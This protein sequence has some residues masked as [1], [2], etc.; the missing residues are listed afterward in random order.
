MPIIKSLLDSTTSPHDDDA[1]DAFGRGEGYVRPR[2]LRDIIAEQLDSLAGQ[3]AIDEMALYRV[4]IRNV[5][6]MIELTRQY[7]PKSLWYFRD[8]PARM[9]MFIQEVIYQTYTVYNHTQQLIDLDAASSTFL[10][11]YTDMIRNKNSLIRPIKPWRPSYPERTA[12]NIS[13]RQNKVI[14][15]ENPTT[16]AEGPSINGAGDARLPMP[17]SRNVMPRSILKKRGG[18]AGTIGT[19]GAGGPLNYNSGTLS[20][21]SY[22]PAS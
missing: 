11:M 20:S 2:P 9:T 15:Y 10:A 3:S 13:Q 4:A 1:Q 12:M 14:V 19:G 16:I 6:N 7:S 8:V 17:A 5:T 18:G 21:F 22:T